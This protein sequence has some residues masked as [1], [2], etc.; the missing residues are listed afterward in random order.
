M[1]DQ[2]LKII[3]SHYVSLSIKIQFYKSVLS[4]IYLLLSPLQVWLQQVGGLWPVP[5]RSGRA[6][7]GQGLRP[8]MVHL[9]ALAVELVLLLVVLMILGV[10]G[11]LLILVRL[12]LKLPDLQT[13]Q[14][15]EEEKT[16]PHRH[17]QVPLLGLH[18]CCGGRKRRE[19]VSLGRGGEE[20]KGGRGWGGGATRGEGGKV[21]KR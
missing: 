15:D 21:G 12:L 5:G 8:G 14:V 1:R 6:S 10:L 4:C 19:V 7:L 13:P 20:N 18:V 2:G 17:E 11:E 16:G 9:L 3:Q